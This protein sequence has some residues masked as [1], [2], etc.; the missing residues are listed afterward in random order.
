MLKRIDCLGVC[1]AMAL[2][3]ACGPALAAAADARTPQYNK[4]WIDLD[5]S[6]AGKPLVSGDPW[7]VIVEYYLDLSEHFEKTTLYLWGTG[8]FVDVPDGKY[9]TRR[10]HIGYPGLG[11][12][13]TLSRPGRGRHVFKLKVPQEL[14]PVRK[15]NP[16]LILAGFRDAAGKGWPWDVRANNAFVRKRGFFEIETGV[17][18]GVFT[19]DEPVSL[20]IRLKSVARDG[21]EKALRYTVHDTAGALVARGE[22]PFAAE[23]AGQKVTLDLDLKPRGVFLVELEVPGWEKRCTTVARIPDLQAITQGRPTPFGMTVH[24]DAPPE[25]V[26]PIARRLGMTWC[27]RFTRWYRLQPGPDVYKLEDLA[28]ELDTSRKHGIHEW[29]CIVDPP[30]FAL[31]GRVE[32]ISYR[33][34]ECRWDVWQEFVRTVTTRLRGKLDGWE[35]LNEITPS[36]LKDPVG[37]YLTM[38]RIGTQ[39]AK[40]IDP[41]V[42]TILAGG[43]YPRAF[44]NQMLT[45][46]VGKYVDAL[47]VHY[48]NGDGILEARQDLA[49]A[50]SAHVAVWEDESARGV[51]AWGV[52][53]LEEMKNTEQCEWVLRQW[54][55]ELAAGAERIIYFGGAGSATGGWDYLLDDL[56]PRPVAATL[57]VLAAKTCGARPLGTFLPGDGG[58]VHLFER[59]GKP[60]LVASAYERSGEKIKLQ[61]GAERLLR[62]DYQGNETSVPA[63]GG[64][65]ELKLGPVPC[66]LEGADLDALKAYVAHDVEV[67]RVGA[68]TSAG[69]AQA[70]RITPRV[71]LLQATEGRLAVRIRNPFARTFSGRIELRLPQGWPAVQPAAFALAKDQ[72]EVR[73]IAVGVPKGVAGRDFT[74][75]VVLVP[76][77]AGLPRVEKPVVLSILAPDMLGNLLPNGDFETP[78]P[79]GKGP[80]G[81]RVD[82]K[83]SL[84]ASAEGLGDGLGRHVLKFQNTT[85]WAY[86]SRTIPVRGG[87]TYLYT[88]WVRNQDMGCG[89]N[90]TLHLAGGR[91][92][93]LFDTQV[94]RCGDNNPS[95]QVFTCR[96]ELPPDAERVS[97]TPLAQGRGWALF[98]NVR[99]TLFEGT[100]YAAEAHRAARPPR[101]DGAL[102]DWITRCPVPLIGP[103]QIAAK[104][105]DYAWKPANL[106]A[107]GYLM[108]DD[109]N[110]YAAFQVRDDVHQPVGA[111]QPDDSKVLEGDSIVL[112][113]DPTKRGPDAEA[114]AFA[115]YL[116]AAAPGSGSGKHTLLRPKERSGGRP[117]GHLFRDS[118]IYDM[119]V[120]RRDGLCTYELRIPWGEI[121]VPGRLGTKLGMSIQLND[122]DGRGRAA[123][124]HWGQG[125]LPAWQPRSFGLVTLVE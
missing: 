37:T 14:E 55:D 115:Y 20:T 64:I 117:A 36:G 48:Q 79:K 104:A 7:D 81:W 16:V 46:G 66:F 10:G 72:T 12:Q 59:D 33:A 41:D 103:N 110:L 53:P 23:R 67:A 121:G 75:G 70:R 89:S 13:V 95:W 118:S 86:S 11:G 120:T 108:W 45:A 19:Y 21:E 42:K 91:E 107:I 9:A 22:K 65:V 3:A 71:G 112:A 68:G 97:F 30:P 73:E 96:K 63:P 54:V 29:L 123:R 125:L 26:W 92:I 62:T 5:A 74:I 102:D 47:P 2:L 113:M 34:F 101:I 93:R 122:N 84:W 56:G 88:A 105:D 114:K 77:A 116:S 31:P 32:P 60:I 44:R 80:E 43:L 24:W 99:V 83:T 124:M 82:G 49:A 106:S 17:P 90:M 15:N 40:A 76:E 52:P 35:W 8:P 69:V 18:G 27:R 39:T 94:M 57:A 6:N 1:C 28:R 58:L 51:N 119:A 85:T 61:V 87:Q 38:C 50:G 98:D 109:A 4:S 100:D 111:A 25:E 78:D